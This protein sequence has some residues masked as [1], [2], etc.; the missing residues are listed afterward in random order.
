MEYGFGLLMNSN[1]TF[2]QT[3]DF[4]LTPMVPEQR[5]A[6]LVAAFWARAR[7]VLTVELRAGAFSDPTR[8][9][10]TPREILQLDNVDYY[11]LSVSH[12]WRDDVIRVVMIDNTL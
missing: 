4:N 8:Q 2:M 9:D 7:Q 6:N 3:A 10:V 1:M 12:D 11:P 5:L